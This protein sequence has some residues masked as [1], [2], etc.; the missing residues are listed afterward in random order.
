MVSGV[1][2][3]DLLQGTAAGGGATVEIA[4][5]LNFEDISVHSPGLFRTSDAMRAV[6][7]QP[8]TATFRR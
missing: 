2:P 6:K 3:M 8:S 1:V 5:E 4:K 7:E